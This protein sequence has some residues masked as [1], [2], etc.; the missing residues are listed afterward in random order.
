M[1]HLTHRPPLVRNKLLDC[2][3]VFEIEKEKQNIIRRVYRY[4]AARHAARDKDFCT[5]F[6]LFYYSPITQK[7]AKSYIYL[8]YYFSRVIACRL[9]RIG[10]RAFTVA[11]KR[12]AFGTRYRYNWE[13]VCNLIAKSHDQETGEIT[14]AFRLTSDAIV[15]ARAFPELD[16][17]QKKD[18][19]KHGMMQ[20]SP[21]YFWM[22][23]GWT[24]CN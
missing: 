9:S 1:R 4:A 21:E 24:T 5:L 18:N 10:K 20:R 15:G 16:R 23:F 19:S 6:V 22:F 8:H 12:L 14:S 3:K 13:L 17:V 11:V 7:P 2:Q